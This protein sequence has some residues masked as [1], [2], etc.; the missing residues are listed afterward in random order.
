[1][2]VQK[3]IVLE[4]AVES[5]AAAQAAERG[6]ADRIELCAE[7]ACGGLTPGAEMMREARS[8]LQIPIFAMIRP[9][10]RNFVYTHQEFGAIRKEIEL[11]REKKMDGVVLGILSGSA[12]VDVERTRELVNLARPMK[13]TFH[14]AF[15]EC[16]D[17][18]RALEDV[19]QTGAD[20]I[21][22]SGGKPDVAAGADSLRELVLAGGGRIVI[23]PGGGITPENFGLVQQV[24][25][26]REF[27]SGLGR[28][29]EYGSK[30]TR[31]FEEKVRQL[32]K[33]K[34]KSF[35]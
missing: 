4:I 16:R 30:D 19:I 18:M 13:V 8:T 22:T 15:D 23:M 10:G 25:G 1:M 27:H 17:M 6:G 28:V 2:D 21:L 12:G 24:T 26:A 29:L 34:V 32:A 31:R 20:R 5:V 14:R 9:R 33:L 11:A 7:L 35:S 3:K